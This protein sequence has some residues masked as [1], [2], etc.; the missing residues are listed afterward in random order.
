LSTKGEYKPGSFYRVCD[1]T[2]VAYRAEDTRREWDGS[3]VADWVFEERQPQDLV[4]GVRDDPSVKWDR[5]RPS[6][7]TFVSLDDALYSEDGEVLIDEEF[8]ETLM[9]EAAS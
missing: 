1:R 3:E 8:G 2:G 7:F 6:T 5:P 4:R 9:P